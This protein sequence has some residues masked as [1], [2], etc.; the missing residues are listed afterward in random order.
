MD[1]N[2]EDVGDHLLSFGGLHPLLKYSISSHTHKLDKFSFAFPSLHFNKSYLSSHT[3][4][5]DSL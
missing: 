3:P 1:V 2:V 5:S 4:P